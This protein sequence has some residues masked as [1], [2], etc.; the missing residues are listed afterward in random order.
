MFIVQNEHSSTEE[1]YGVEQNG[2][3]IQHLGSVLT[4]PGRLLAFP[5]VLQ[6]QVQP[7]KLADTTKPG[8]R[9]ILALFLVDPHIRILSTANVA[10]QRVDWWAEQ[11]R[12]L[13]PFN[14]LPVEIFS[15]IVDL[16]GGQGQGV[17]IS[18]EEAVATRQEL[19]DQRGA[20]VEY[21]N[22]DMEE[23]SFSLVCP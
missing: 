8:H 14:A 20:L 22:D 5:N 11:V 2:P 23:V 15:M 19:M 13:A 17:P 6:H 21:V 18:W 10:P 3:A 9:K 12:A 16:V 1:F 4:R 7:F